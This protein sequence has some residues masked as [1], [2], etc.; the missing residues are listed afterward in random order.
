VTTLFAG[1]P[2]LAHCTQTFMGGTARFLAQFFQIFFP[3][4]VLFGKLMDDSGSVTAIAGYM[5]LRLGERPAILAVV[6]RS[7]FSVALASRQDQRPQGAG[8][9]A[10]RFNEQA[11]ERDLFLGLNL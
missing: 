8:K 6:L 5:T 4:G 9:I 2:L 7:R 1:E 10:D 11:I 3:V